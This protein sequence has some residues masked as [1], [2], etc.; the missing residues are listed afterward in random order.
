MERRIERLTITN[1]HGL[2][3]AARLELPGDGPPQAYVLLAHCFTCGMN[4]AP[5]VRIG[6]VLTSRGLALMRFDATGLGDSEG[7]FADTTLLTT[8][9]DVVDTAAYLRRHHAAPQLLVG[10][11]QGGAAVI[12]A[13]PDIPEA[14]AVA[15]IGTHADPRAT[16]RCLKIDREALRQRGET[17]IT[18]AGRRF[19]I[20]PP[21]VEAL[22]DFRLQPYVESLGRPLLVLHSPEDATVP[23]SEGEN[24][25]EHAAHPKSFVALTGAHHLMTGDGDA[26]FAG[27]LLAAFALRH[28]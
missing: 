20:R 12:A 14:G 25:F 13:A 1:R 28:L 7:D 4:L 11:S 17:D 3:L 10:H 5:Y 24:L 6:R 16:L 27:E 18:V 15:V 21:F 23:I 26:E 8:I 9:D 2:R 22:E 19:S